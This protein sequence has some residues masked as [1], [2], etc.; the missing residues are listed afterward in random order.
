MLESWKEF[1]S[2]NGDGTKVQKVQDKMPRV[3]K[4]WRNTDDGVEE[5]FDMLFADDETQSNPASLKFLQ[6]AHAWK[7]QQN[8]TTEEAK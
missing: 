5:Y 8:D 7:T 6:M 1:E 4:K 3:V 2:E